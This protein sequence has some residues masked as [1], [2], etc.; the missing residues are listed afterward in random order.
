MKP[1]EKLPDSSDWIY[2]VTHEALSDM[3]VRVQP[4]WMCV[5]HDWDTDSHYFAIWFLGPFLILGWWWASARWSL[6]RWA[7]WRIANVP[8]GYHC[9]YWFL[10]IRSVN[11]WTWNRT[12]PHSDSEEYAKVERDLQ[13]AIKAYDE[14]KAEAMKGVFTNYINNLPE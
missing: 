14:A 3:I 6:E 5:H 13:A 4:G 12:R 10:A 9:R 8:G 11:K 1:T 7:R 2:K